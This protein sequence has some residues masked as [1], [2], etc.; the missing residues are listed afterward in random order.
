MDQGSAEFQLEA[1]ISKIFASVS[2]VMC[3]YHHTLLTTRSLQEAAWVVADECIQ[4][5]GGMGFMTVSEIK[6]ERLDSKMVSLYR[7]AVWK[8]CFEIFASSVSLKAAM[9]FFVCLSLSLDCSL[10]AS[11]FRHLNNQ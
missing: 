2:C 10:L 5:H 4:L 8:E 1:A 11:I 7:N 3:Y 9:T 6:E